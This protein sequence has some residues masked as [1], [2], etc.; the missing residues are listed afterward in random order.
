[1]DRARSPAPPPAHA[2]QPAPAAMPSASWPEAAVPPAADASALQRLREAPPRPGQAATFYYHAQLRHAAVKVLPGEYFVHDEDI[3]ITTT[4]GSCI[5][6]CLWD[7][8][9][10]LGGMNHFVLPAGDD[11]AAGGGRYGEQA[12]ALLLQ[13]MLRRGATRDAIEAKVFGGATVVDGIDAIDIGA[14]NTRFVLDHLQRER[15]PVVSMDVLDLYPR[16]V[17]FLPASGRVLVRRLARAETGPPRA[18]GAAWPT[19]PS[20]ELADP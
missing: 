18:R 4:L 5:A 15:I 16:L 12:M 13:E 11:T 2:A 10:G 1:M 7:R 20:C 9:R 17:C 3:L 6:A 8:R 19:T 14:L